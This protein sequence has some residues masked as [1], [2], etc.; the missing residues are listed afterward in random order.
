MTSLSSA[1]TALWCNR[2]VSGFDP[3]IQLR[4]YLK[5]R[6]PSETAASISR[7]AKANPILRT[8]FVPD[9]RGYPEARIESEPDLRVVESDELRYA[10]DLDN[11][12]TGHTIFTVAPHD[13]GSTI[14]A[15]FSHMVCDR[16]SLSLFAE[17]L[18]NDELVAAD[19][20]YQRWQQDQGPQ[21]DELIPDL[22]W[23]PD[24]AGTLPKVDSRRNAVSWKEV[25]ALSASLGVAPSLPIMA[26][27]AIAL[28]TAARRSHSIIAFN[29]VGRLRRR[30]R[31]II[32]PLAMPRFLMFDSRT[33]KSF[34][35]LIYAWRSTFS[36]SIR[37]VLDPTSILAAGMHRY[38][39]AGLWWIGRTPAPSINFEHSNTRREVESL[40]DI[41]S[42]PKP[43]L[44]RHGGS[45]TV[46]IGPDGILSLDMIDSPTMSVA[47]A[48][49]I[50]S[51]TALLIADVARRD[52]KLADSA[53]AACTD[54]S[55]AE[56][57]LPVVSSAE[58]T[59]RT[60]V[61]MHDHPSNNNWMF[62]FCNAVGG[63]HL[64]EEGLLP[65]VART[66][67]HEE[68]LPKRI[69]VVHR[70][71]DPTFRSFRPS[72]A[73]STHPVT[74]IDCAAAHQ[75]SGLTAHEFPHAVFQRDP[76][77][78]GLALGRSSARGAIGV[79]NMGI[80]E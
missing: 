47:T 74:P 46:S 37:G 8:K 40:F 72:G 9:K 68:L 36:E 28:A 62:T 6:S 12:E 22:A 64:S 79:S 54:F 31:N 38:T 55:S 66:S 14:L 59:D 49:F 1:Q 65:A 69:L 23:F 45:L 13:A 2:F 3:R 76:T 7:I 19:Y 58:L 34:A 50:A 5:D 75:A 25:T 39:D 10:S 41:K 42:A 61:P 4:I 20:D 63:R 26:C 71:G 77:V 60:K 29:W 56:E 30:D 21:N 15:N 32:G 78:G 35:N 44:V 48:A 33:H 80:K 51:E 18:I 43:Q 52:Q 17:Q 73:D 70:C 67:K 57:C 53:I 11:I 27:Y 24:W 16:V